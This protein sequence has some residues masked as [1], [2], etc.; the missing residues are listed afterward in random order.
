MNT[1]RTAFLMIA[2]TSLLMLIGSVLGGRDGA[3]I[4]LIFAG[5]MNFFTYWLSDRVVL[6]MYRAREVGP[7]HRL[8]RI[9][10][11]LAARAGMPMPRV[12]VIPTNSPNAFATGRNP[13]HAAVAATEGILH[14]L[15][16]SE[17]EAVLAH[18]L[19]HVRHRDILIATIAATIAGAI[20]MLA[21]WA[22]WAAIFGGFGGDDED[23][24]GGNMLVWLFMMIVAPIAAMLIQLAISRSREYAADEGSAKLSGKPLALA[25]ALAKIEQASRYY[26]LRANEATAH[27]FIVNPL[28]GGLSG[29]FR[30]HP[31]TEERI[32]RLRRIA[33]QMGLR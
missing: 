19:S 30:T 12:Y 7:D 11:R 31:P 6:A 21:N 9:V 16:D 29:L 13:R 22:R 32:R 5:G 17:L 20:M 26:P 27:M 2:L 33:A 18:E 28:K 8:Y 4:A 24:G 3:I 10:G 1:I 25:S 14:M 23:R 15:D